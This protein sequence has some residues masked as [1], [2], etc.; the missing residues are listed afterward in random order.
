[1]GGWTLREETEDTCETSSLELPNAF[2]IESRNLSQNVLN[3][4]CSSGELKYEM[5]LFLD[6]LMD[7]GP[8]K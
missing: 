8:F 2:T 1:M 6:Y 4:S 7:K 3:S 5:Q